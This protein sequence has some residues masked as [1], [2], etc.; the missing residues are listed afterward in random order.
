MKQKHVEGSK[1]PEGGD[2]IK[3]CAGSP[4]DVM[5]FGFA[6]PRK[7]LERNARCFHV[8]NKIKSFCQDDHLG[9][10]NSYK[11][12]VVADIVIG[13]VDVRG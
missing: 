9:L 3:S 12:I 1:K 6:V 11:L 5:A 7:L 10:C 13:T 4:R 2:A 8:S